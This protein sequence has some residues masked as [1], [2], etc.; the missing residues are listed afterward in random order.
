VG[1]ILERVSEWRELDDTTAILTIKEI[2]KS[3]EECHHELTT[4]TNRFMV[5]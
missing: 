4:L 5:S 3:I 1:K 2:L